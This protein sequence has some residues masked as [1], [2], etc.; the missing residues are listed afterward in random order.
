MKLHLLTWP[1]RITLLRIG[2]L[3][4]L[5]FL[6]YNYHFWV[7]IFAAGLSILIIAMDWL[8]GYLAR[9]LDE[10][11]VLGGLLDIA[12]DR[13][14]E[15]VLWICLADLKLIPI[16]IPIVVISRGISTDTIRGYVLRFGYTAFGQKTMMHSPLGR[17][18]TGSRIMRSGYAVMKAVSF[19]LLL[20]ASAFQRTGIL[21][22]EWVQL[23]LRTGFWFSVATAIVCLV[24]GI[25]VIIEGTTL[26]HRIG[27]EHD[28]PAAPEQ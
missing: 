27:Q 6:I 3:F 14:V 5:V 21:P 4:V 25:P 11:T 2:L 7:R 16:W 19:G 23:G 26:I 9:K 17:F 8:D 10:K 22:G 15:M 20:L 1:N 28:E 24:R 13:I 18:L 12:G